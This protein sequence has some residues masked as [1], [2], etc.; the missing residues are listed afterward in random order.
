VLAVTVLQKSY[1]EG[2]Q[3]WARPPG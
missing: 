2:A 1:S 3:W